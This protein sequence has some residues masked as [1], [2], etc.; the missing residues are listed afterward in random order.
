MDNNTKMIIAVALIA[1][2]AVSVGVYYFTL[3]PA[4]PEPT[5]TPAPTAQPTPTPTAAPTPTPAPT[6][7][8]E[9]VLIWGTSENTV[10]IEGATVKATPSYIPN[11]MIYE[12]LCYYKDGEPILYPQLALSWERVEPDVWEF[13][14][15]P[16]VLFHDG[17]PWNAEA[18]KFNL[19]RT[20]EGG[21]GHTF[22]L[23]PVVDEVT[24]VS[25]LVVQIKTKQPIGFL[26]HVMAIPGATFSSPTAVAEHG[27]DFEQVS[28]AGTGPFKFVEWVQGDRIVVE[29][30]TGYWDEMRMPKLDKIIFKHFA[31][32]ATLAL[33]IEAGNIDVAYRHL[34]YA[35]WDRVAGN[36]HINTQQN[37]SQYIQFIV[38]NDEFE[39]LDNYL[40][41]KAIAYAI[42]YNSLLTAAYHGDRYYS[43]YPPGW[44]VYN[45]A[46]SVIQYDPVYAQELMN[47]AGYPQG[48]PGS[49]PLAFRSDKPYEPLWGAVVQQNLAEIGIT[50]ELRPLDLST[51]LAE[52]LDPGL[53][54]FFYQ[55]QFLYAD[56]DYS[57]YFCY[58]TDGGGARRFGINDPVLDAM[59]MEAR[60]ETDWP[61]RVT[62]YQ[63]IQNYGNI[64]ILNFALIGREQDIIFYRDNI[65]GITLGTVNWAFDFALIDKT[66]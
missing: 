3:P 13:N 24:V 62:Q 15:R 47:Q 54:M 36:A 26:P 2:V 58:H 56:P 52:T 37:P 46:Q 55:H 9:K 20:I 5:P 48:L 34:N 35:D 66:E 40:V 27:E 14:L 51:F 42:D 61:T 10:G 39:P 11:D 31:D 65:S 43:L 63:Q 16:D 38:F 57:A 6:P 33:E 25:D 30:W 21:K 50:V 22:A 7:E 64:D 29:D 49:I 8:P 19:E 17:T 45:T 59:I 32:P 4:E 41:R 44:E 28:Q 60:Q 18:V 1:I 23:K 53:P 12:K